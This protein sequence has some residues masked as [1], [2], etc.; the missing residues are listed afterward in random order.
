MSIHIL[1]PGLLSTVQDNGRFGLQ[2]QG[3]IVSGAMDPFAF[4]AANVL[5]GNE[6]NEAVLELTLMGPSIRFDTDSLIS[7]CGGDLSPSIG[8]EPVPLWRTIFVQAG[9]TLE[10]GACRGGARAYLAIAGGIDVPLVMQSRSTYLRAG[11]GGHEGRALK[12]GDVLPC[13]VISDLV[14]SYIK[15]YQTA[16][17]TKPFRA[18]DWFMSNQSLP[19]Y[20]NNPMI[21]VIRGREFDHFTEKSQTLFFSN[22]F[23]LTPQSDRMGYRMEGG[24]LTC[25]ESHEMISEAVAFGTIQV[26]SEGNPIVL[27]ADRQTIGGYPKIAQVITVDLPVLAQAKPGDSVRFKEISLQKAEAMYIQKELE[28]ERLAKTIRL[29]LKER[30]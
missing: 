20:S 23:R 19:G 11:I 4:R 9:T 25:K 6:A 15:A 28:F 16:A 3:V 13:G 30:R 8:G 7:I 24:V 17:H 27:M 14:A 12:S 2:Q 22:T 10:F 21:R 26:P 29:Y 5:V 18:A 1:S